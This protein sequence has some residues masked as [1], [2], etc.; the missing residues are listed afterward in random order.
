MIQ[1]VRQRGIDINQVSGRID[2]EEPARRM[3]EIFDGVLQFLEHVLLAR[4]VAG[5]VR[6]R[7]HR[8]AR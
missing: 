7:P 8:V 2:R 6:Y 3:I 1:P 5:D 4:A